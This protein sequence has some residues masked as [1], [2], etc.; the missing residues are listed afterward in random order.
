MKCGEFYR[1]GM[2]GNIYIVVRRANVDYALLS[3]HDGQTIWASS[4]TLAILHT[5][6]QYDEFTKFTGKISVENGLT[7]H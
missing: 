2:D 6:I 1:C 3:I 4:R 7:L 5:K